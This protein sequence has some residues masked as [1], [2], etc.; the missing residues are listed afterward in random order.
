MCPANHE[1]LVTPVYAG[2]GK[3]LPAPSAKKELKTITKGKSPA[4]KIATKD[5]AARYNI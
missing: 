5:Y 1:K 2:P 3:Y 4:L